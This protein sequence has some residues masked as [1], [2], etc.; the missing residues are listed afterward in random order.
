QEIEP[1]LAAIELLLDAGDFKRADELFKSRFHGGVTF[2]DLPAQHTGI[3]CATAFIGDEYR[4]QRCAEK[5]ESK[6]G[7]AGYLLLS[8]FFAQY[9]GEFETALCFHQAGQ[10]VLAQ[11]GED[12]QDADFATELG[13]ILVFHLGSLTEAEH[14]ALTALGIVRRTGNQRFISEK[15]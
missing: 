12:I 14:C 11:A 6:E 2:L 7:L 8:G 13:L 5:L 3:R 1:I 15:E 4:R 9:A 10:Q